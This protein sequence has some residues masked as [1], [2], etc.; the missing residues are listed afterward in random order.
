MYTTG[1]EIHHALNHDMGEF[2]IGKYSVDGY[3]EGT[4]R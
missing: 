2:R 4:K 1:F 3:C